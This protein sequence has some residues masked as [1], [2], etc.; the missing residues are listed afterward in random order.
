M[1]AIRT[2]NKLVR[3]ISRLLDNSP[4]PVVK[5]KLDFLQE[6]TAELQSEAKRIRQSVSEETRA[7]PEEEIAIAE[8]ALQ[9]YQRA[10]LRTWE[11]LVA[12]RIIVL[13]SYVDFHVV[14]PYME[15]LPYLFHYLRKN[16]QFWQ[17]RVLLEYPRYWD[18]YVNNNSFE[19]H[20]SLLKSLLAESVQS[21]TSMTT[22]APDA[23]D[24]FYLLYQKARRLTRFLS[25]LGNGEVKLEDR[26]LEPIATLSVPIGTKYLHNPQYVVGLDELNVTVTDMVSRRVS[27]TTFTRRSKHSVLSFHMGHQCFIIYEW[28][29]AE[30]RAAVLVMFLNDAE[31]TTKKPKFLPH[32]LY[33][34]NLN[35]HDVVYLVEEP[36][37][38]DIDDSDF[39]SII[40]RVSARNLA[41][42]TVGN[43]T[44]VG[45]YMTNYK[46]LAP[47]IDI[48]FAPEGRYVVRHPAFTGPDPIE[49]MFDGPDTDHLRENSWMVR[50]DF[51]NNYARPFLFV[52]R[53]LSNGQRYIALR[54]DIELKSMYGAGIRH[55]NTLWIED[56]SDPMRHLPTA[57]SVQLSLDVETM[58][59]IAFS[60]NILWE[61]DP[62]TGVTSFYDLWQLY[63]RTLGPD[64]R[65][66]ITQKLY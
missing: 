42:W 3:K 22:G 11:I 18:H 5:R 12:G 19:I 1:D 51:A 17:R 14:Y 62:T 40:R 30:D 45:S 4:V 44:L 55:G 33:F 7:R 2:H 36:E 24:A 46:T 43:T 13:F 9:D 31:F 47:E 65:P 53:L 39:S 56:Q 59:T 37:S 15:A 34:D 64:Q 21:W 52:K 57:F 48:A 60:G 50:L 41:K 28:N 26:V 6:Q 8:Q 38:S 54:G 49:M 35:E 32:R 20:P 23:S 29:A 10:V 16:K 58:P 25:K 66:L 27:T 61:M 63:T